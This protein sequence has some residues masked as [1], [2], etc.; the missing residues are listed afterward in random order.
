MDSVKNN[1]KDKNKIENVI[2]KSL[3][4]LQEDGIFAFVIY[5]GSIS[6]IDEKKDAEEIQRKGPIP[7]RDEEKK[8]DEEKVAEEIQKKII[9][10]FK[11]KLKMISSTDVINAFQKLCE[12]I[13]NMLFAKEIIERTLIYARYRARSL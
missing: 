12:D 11:D 8:R 1:V 4:I 10:M 13:D 5:L 7:R 9:E 3:G 6:K 2:Q